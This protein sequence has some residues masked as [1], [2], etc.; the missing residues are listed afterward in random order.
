MKPAPEHICTV[1]L[2]TVLLLISRSALAAS[3]SEVGDAG[4]TMFS[5]QNT[6]G[7]G[8]LTTITGTLPDDADIDL[9]KI[10]ITDKTSFYAGI[11]PLAAIADP[12][13]WL[14]DGSG[15]GIAHN[16]TVQAGACSITGALVPSNGTYYLGVS[17]S[18]RS[19]RAPVA[20]SGTGA[21]SA[22]NMLRMEPRRAAADRLGW[23]AGERS[24]KLFH[25]ADRCRFC[26]PGARTVVGRP[27]DPGAHR[28]GTPAATSRSGLN[29]G[30]TSLRLALRCNRNPP[31]L[32]SLSPSHTAAAPARAAR[33]LS[34]AI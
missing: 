18:G 2:S 32:E 23:H 30:G 27:G 11:Q 19:H 16:A 4:D 14:F 3:W 25:H 22:A 8:A 34:C 7:N 33:Q 6:V 21:T 9:Y 5:S 28:G 29:T 31:T 20:T 15:N 24:H 26:H 13:I 17:S 1:F 12:D 10:Q